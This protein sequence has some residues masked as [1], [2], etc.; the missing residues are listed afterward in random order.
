MS[1]D[2]RPRRPQSWEHLLEKDP[3]SGTGFR[4]GIVAALL[5]HAVIFAISW[6]TIAQAPPNEPDEILYRVPI[7]DFVPQPPEPEPISIDI[8]Q[9]PP[10]G[11]PIIDGPP[12][13][14][15][16]PIERP[17]VEVMR[18]PDT[19]VHRTPP[20]AILEPPP[21]VE[22]P[23]IV[24]VGADI[25][26]PEITHKV[27]PRYTEPARYAGIRGVVILELIIDAAGAV[28]SV[29]VHRG[30][31]LG[32]TQSA[33]DAVSQWRFKPSE[34]SGRPVAVR[35]ILTVRFSLA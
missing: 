6:P 20:P 17:T 34:F 14:P 16:E 27:E 26:P 30:L 22:E 3:H 24:F 32:L 9:R 28:E 31:P 11:P 5:I 29:K 4:L 10:Q 2:D 7:Y 8:P 18:I 19:G 13:P 21:K 33:I 23:K 1:S 15:S 12:E 25:E 35:Y